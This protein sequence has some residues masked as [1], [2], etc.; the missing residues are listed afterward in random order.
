MAAT[1]AELEQENEEL[2]AQRDL[3]AEGEVER[4]KQGNHVP[5]EGNTPKSGKSDELGEFTKN[6][7]G[8]AAAD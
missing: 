7:F 1:K 5:R 4:K 2:K 6:L 8:R 3:I